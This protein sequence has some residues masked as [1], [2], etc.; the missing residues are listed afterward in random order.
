MVLVTDSRQTEFGRF[1]GFENLTW[2]HFERD[3]IDTGLLADAEKFWIDRYHQQVFDC[4][5]PPRAPPVAA[6]LY[7]QTR[8]L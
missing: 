6:W 2:C 1:L 7:R 3:L 4:L 5:S 8:P